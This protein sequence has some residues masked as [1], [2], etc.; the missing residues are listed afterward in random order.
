M[1]TVGG[2][3]WGVGATHLEVPS[4]EGLVEELAEHRE[5]VGTVSGVGWRGRSYPPGSPVT[6]GAGR[7]AR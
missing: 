7:G 2:V 3:R 1:G 4:R 5:E 6:G